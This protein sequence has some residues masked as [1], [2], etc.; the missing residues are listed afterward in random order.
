[1]CYSES[2]SIYFKFLLS[3]FNKL[4]II[5]ISNTSLYRTYS[6]FS[7]DDLG[8]YSNSNS[9]LSYICSRKSRNITS[10]HREQP[11]IRKNTQFPHIGFC[12]DKLFNWHG[13]EL[14]E[15]ARLASQ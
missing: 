4:C 10:P 14:T 7:V 8:Q 12:G 13:G 2:F 11:H 1:M 3:S 5:N 6:S 9:N 15:Q